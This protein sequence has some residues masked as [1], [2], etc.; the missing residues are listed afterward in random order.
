MIERGDWLEKIM[1]RLPV[2]QPG[3]LVASSKGIGVFLGN[4]GGNDRFYGVK[5]GGRTLLEIYP[6]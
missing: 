6:G 4:W 1:K 5:R 2:M 3:A